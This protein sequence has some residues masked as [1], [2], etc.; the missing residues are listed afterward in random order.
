[1]QNCIVCVS[2]EGFCNIFNLSSDSTPKPNTTLKTN[3]S[4]KS[5]AIIDS[6]EKNVP[7]VLTPFYTQR[8]PANAKV[9]CLADID[10][11]GQNEFIVGLT[12][13]V[14]RTYRC[15][16]ISDKI[17]LVGIHKWEFIDQIGTLSLNPVPIRTTDHNDY[18][19][20]L[21]TYNILV[22]QPGGTYAKLECWNKRLTITSDDQLDSS[23][24][25]SKLMPEYYELSISQM[26]NP[27]ISTGI[28]TLYSVFIFIYYC[29]VIVSGS[30]D[31][32]IN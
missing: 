9:A 3:L 11:D 17:K 19:Y 14:V 32:W 23:Q 20:G 24:T 29:S 13:R 26:R 10:N 30:L 8:L 18:G 1:M 5:N 2:V 12:D 21:K 16:Q 31:H 7:R 15:V 4:S 6:D 22:A 25:V 27:S 28:H